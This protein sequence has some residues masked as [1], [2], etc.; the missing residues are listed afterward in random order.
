M[1]RI[2]FRL[3]LLFII[4][5]MVDLTICL[6]CSG[7]GGEA[8][9]YRP[10]LDESQWWGRRDALVRCVAASLYG[11]RNDK[12]PD[13]IEL[14]LLFDEDGCVMRMQSPPLGLQKDDVPT[15]RRIVTMWRSAASEAVRPHKSS[16]FGLTSTAADGSVTCIREPWT[17]ASGN[18]G[19]S[20][21]KPLPAASSPTSSDMALDMSRLESKRDILECIQQRCPLEFLRKHRLNSHADVVLRKTN[22]TKLLA[23]WNDWVGSGDDGTKEW[24]A[25]V[26]DRDRVIEENTGQTFRAILLDRFRGGSIG[27]NDTKTSD[28]STVPPAVMAAV[29]HESMDSELPCWEG[30]KY[31]T[32][33]PARLCIFLGAVRDMTNK[34]NA[35]L[36][37]ACSELSIP[38]LQFRLG[39][40]PEFTSKI[41]SVVTY[42]NAV[43]SLGAAIWNMW[44]RKQEMLKT[45]DDGAKNTAAPC[46]KQRRLHVICNIPISSAELTHD[47]NARS[48]VLWCLV[49]LCVCTLWRS[50]LA[51]SSALASSE[52]SPAILENVLSVVFQDGA[53]LTLEQEDLVKTLAEKHQAAPTEHQI[54]AALCQKRDE[55]SFEHNE[56]SIKRFLKKSIKDW[57]KSLE[58]HQDSSCYYL[59]LSRNRIA[60][61]KRSLVDCAYSNIAVQ[62]SNTTNALIFAHVSIRSDKTLDLDECNYASVFENLGVPV[63]ASNFSPS[64]EFAQDGEASTIT[65]LQHLQYQQR[66]IPAIHACLGSEKVGCKKQKKHERKS[67]KKKSSKK[68][69]REELLHNL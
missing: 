60:A 36:A 22:R 18:S 47:L 26:E 23:A 44:N 30:I 49:R 10:N 58:D 19:S 40:V 27:D 66:L 42:H 24:R 67:K 46:G 12:R 21:D 32:N 59:E 37:K 55:A 69:K 64:D 53:I 15:E 62:E 43:G 31:E 63:V 57:R 20:N 25:S 65:M 38:L 54:L 13:R 11:P 16:G 34:E 5:D 45:E 48:R 50:K 52:R 2:E 29:L 51:S 1:N 14:C 4:V 8:Q 61:D 6:L 41:L 56:P 7:K 28:D 9:S 39:P 3:T 68:R 17:Y 33:G 35:I